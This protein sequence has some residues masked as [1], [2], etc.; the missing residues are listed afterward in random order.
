[1][2][3]LA[4]GEQISQRILAPLLLEHDVMGFEP[5]VL[6]ATLLTGVAVAHQT[7]DAQVLI[8]PR[9]ILVLGAAQRRLVEASDI[10]LDIFN[11]HGRNRQWDLVHH[12]DHLLDIGF[13]RG[14]QASTAFTRCAIVKTWWTVPLSSPAVVSVGATTIHFVLDIQAM[15]ELTRQEDLSFTHAAKASKAASL[16]NAECDFLYLLFT[17]P[18]E[19]DGKRA[20]MDS[21]GFAIP[22]QLACFRGLTRHQGMTILVDD[23]D[24][25]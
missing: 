13:D 10:H 16:I 19:F 25:G 9:R 17:V 18:Q 12:P 20:T 24:V 5:N 15:M 7:G 3:S 2:T 21:D 14:R 11:D 1:M 22:Q 23:I 8:E 6:L 4:E